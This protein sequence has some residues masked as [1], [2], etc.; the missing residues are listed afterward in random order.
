MFTSKQAYLRD[1]RGCF[2]LC[3]SE[4]GLFTGLF[5]GWGLD[6]GIP[7]ELMPFNGPARG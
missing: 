3:T 6:S 7:H 2:S 5:T 4:I 1:S